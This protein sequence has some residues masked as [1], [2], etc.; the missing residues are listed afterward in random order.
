MECQNAHPLIPSYLDG[1]LTEAQAAPLRKHLLDCQPC[2]G[3]AQ[4]D[5]NMKRWFVEPAAVAVPRDF[6]SRVAR[7]AFAGD[8]G[9]RYSEP[10]VRGPVPLQAVGKAD[11]RNM[12]FVLTMTAL[13]ATVLLCFAIAIKSL[14]LPTGAELRADDQPSLSVDQALQRLDELNRTQLNQGGADGAT[15]VNPARA[16]DA[17]RAQ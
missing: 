3:S 13:A 1:E 10:V 11:E 6:A 17:R 12:R 9:E 15:K 4:S 7:R 16:P 2:R 5:K 8:R 14:S